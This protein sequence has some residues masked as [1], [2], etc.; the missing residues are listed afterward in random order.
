[1]SAP[2]DEEIERVAR[3]I[4]EA[5]CFGQNWPAGW[6]SLSINQRREWMLIARWHLAQLAARPVSSEPTRE[7]IAET[8]RMLLPISMEAG[9]GIGFGPWQIAK[10]ALVQAEEFEKAA[11]AYLA[12]GAS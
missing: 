6:D 2:T 4:Y 12:G 7:R 11:A 9:S 10:C 5:C 1:M 3:E 8:A